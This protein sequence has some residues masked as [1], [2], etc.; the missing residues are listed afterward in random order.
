MPYNDN[1]Y[2][3]C[4][5]GFN[6]IDCWKNEDF[7]IEKENMMPRM[8]K[9][10]QDVDCVEELLNSKPACISFETT[11]TANFTKKGAYVVLDFGKELCGSIR[12]VCRATKSRPAMFRIT[13]GE[14]L[15]EACSSIGEKNATNDHSPRDFIAAIS[16]M[17]DISFG[18]SGFRFARIELLTE[19]SVTIRN[20]FAVNFLPKFEKEGYITTSDA[21]LNKIIDTAIYTLKL[22][23]QNGY[24]WDGIKR[25][26]LVWSGDLNQE[27]ISSI[28]LFG[29]NRNITN[30]LDFLREETPTT[31]WINLIPT[32][33]AWWVINLCDHCRLTGNKDY[34]EHNKDYAKSIMS[35]LNA[36][37]TE[38]GKMNLSQNASMPFFFDWPTYGTPDA[39]VGT[40]TILMYAAKLLLEIEENEDCHA[41]IRK[42]SPYLDEP[43]Q[44]KQTRAFQ[45]LAGRQ[46]KGDKEFLEAGGAK[47]FSTFMSYYILSADSKV[48]GS[49]ML[50][51]IKEY[52]GAMLSR[53]ATTFWEDFHM[54]WL[55]GSGQIDEFPKEGQK[56]IHGDY[57]DF[58]YKGFRHSLCHGWASG[59]LAFIYEFMLGLKLSDGGEVYDVAPHTLGIEEIHAK[60]PT[61][62]GW[63]I[64]D[65]TNNKVSITPSTDPN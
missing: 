57:G 53:G 11:S 18:M 30:S 45:I 33:S 38:N 5:E 47:G 25:D 4:K 7:C 54:E 63:L 16:D 29:D 6:M 39:I 48:N 61:K 19:E 44:F 50:S 22:N 1:V 21:E 56:D 23:F 9:C 43:C 60:I 28:Y 64:I 42:L 40:A 55:D 41:I 20:I 10:F 13:L 3:L 34:F 46:A 12:I 26:R 27:I 35:R 2:K 17:S 36:S 8:I 37:I 62:N 65:V 49:E 59:V 58:C 24:I 31:D 52:F 15:S 51:I 14:S 32:Y